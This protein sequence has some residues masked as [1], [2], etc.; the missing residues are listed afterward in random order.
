MS[1]L[2]FHDHLGA[3]IV[4]RESGEVDIA[5]EL[6]AHHRNR[7]GVVHGGVLTALLDAALGGAVV[8]SIPKEWWCATT[9]LSTQFLDG[10]GTGTILAS[11]RVVRRGGRVAFAAG[12]V[13]DDAGRLLAVAHGTWH[14][15]HRRPGPRPE[16]ERGRVI[17]AATNERL[18][19]GKVV[20]V[21]R[22]YAEHAT[23]M[24]ADPGRPPVFFL[25]PQ[26][27]VVS[28]ATKLALPTDAGEVHHEVELAAVVGLD[29]RSIPP[30]RALDH[31]MGFAVGLDLTLRE[32][33]AEA[34]K[35]GEP[36][37][38][39][40]GFDDSAPLS[41]VVGREAVGDGSGLEITLSVNGEQRQRGNTSEMTRTIPEL[42][43]AISRR[44]TLQRGDVILTG[45]PAGVGPVLPGDRIEARIERVG[46]LTLEIEAA[47]G[48]GSE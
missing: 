48:E 35:R 14:L 38:V 41:K 12:E 9:S 37:A 1:K 30:E 28:G 40:K 3:E 2:P 16:V 21:G 33:Q 42:V 18:P 31:L 10:A 39:A 25:K 46:D 13:R 4:R 45:T 6:A 22:N 27:A 11:G 26:T 17:V 24:G 36:W 15:W 44:M 43:A 19:V 34:K 23:E 32:L 20:A 5:L 8:A 47:R 29:G 7:R